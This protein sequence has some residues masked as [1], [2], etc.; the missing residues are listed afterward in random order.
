MSHRPTPKRH[1]YEHRPPEAK[2]GLKQ[3][4]AEL[5]EIGATGIALVLGSLLAIVAIIAFFFVVPDLVMRT[6]RN[7]VGDRLLVGALGAFLIAPAV[8][9]SY[10]TLRGHQTATLT[11]RQLIAAGITLVVLGVLGA[12]ML[13]WA[14]TSQSTE[15]GF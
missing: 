13:I 9:F 10:R 11:R 6:A 3:T 15:P 12:M 14:L 1:L 8:M 5:A 4:V 7:L 2:A